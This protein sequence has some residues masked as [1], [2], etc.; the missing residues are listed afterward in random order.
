VKTEYKIFLGVAT[1]L[2]GAAI[3]YGF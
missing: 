3:V 2:F 1:F